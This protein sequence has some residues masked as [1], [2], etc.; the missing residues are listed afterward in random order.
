VPQRPR[1]PLPVTV[2]AW[3]YVTSLVN[4]LFLPFIRVPTPVFLF[5]F[6]LPDRIGLAILILTCLVFTVCG[7]GILKLK[8]WSYTLTMGLQIFWL[9][10]TVVSMLRSDYKAVME[11]FLK[12]TQASMHLPESQY[13]WNP[14][15]QYFA[16]FM[17][18]VLLLAGA[19]LALLI[20]YRKRFLE[21]ASAAAALH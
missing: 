10:S 1:S 20:Y 12:Q 4:L 21:A 15:M 7:I 16:W 17:A 18:I 9:V 19:L 5:G 6:L 13:S 8:P 14:F 2:L 3:F 11:A